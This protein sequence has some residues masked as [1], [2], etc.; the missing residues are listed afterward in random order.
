MLFRWRAA[1]PAPADRFEATLILFCHSNTC[2]SHTVHVTNRQK[3]PPKNFRTHNFSP[4]CTFVVFS[5]L[6]QAW[7]WRPLF[8]SPLGGRYSQVWLHV[9][10]SLVSLP[11]VLEFPWHN[12]TSTTF[13]CRRDSFV[14]SWKRSLDYCKWLIGKFILSLPPSLSLS[15]SPSACM[16]VHVCLFHS[17]YLLFLSPLLGN[18]VLPGQ[19]VPF[20]F[21]PHAHLDFYWHRKQQWYLPRLCFPV[22]L[23]AVNK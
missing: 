2:S 19:A 3:R 12:P 7:Q 23:T 20:A 10:V 9:V 11:G 4:M 8:A 16:G 18:R 21:S 5:T 13:G 22:H 1:K 14:L 17:P 15:L 6:N